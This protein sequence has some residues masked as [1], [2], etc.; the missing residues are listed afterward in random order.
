MQD[1]YVAD[2]GDFSKYALLRALAG[3][4]DPL[5]LGVLW[6]LYPDEGHNSD[7]RHIGYL[8]QPVMALHDPITHAKLGRLVAEGRRSVAAVQRAEILPVGTRF[9]SDI[10]AATGTPTDR[11]EHR[12]RWFARGAQGMAASDLVF[13]DPDNGIE[14]RALDKRSFRAGKYVFWSEIEAIWRAGKSL[15]VYNHLNRSAPAAT[16]TNLLAVEF[17]RR[18]PDAAET[19]PLLFRRGS[20]RHMWIIVQEG[21]RHRLEP[22]IRAFLDQGWIQDADLSEPWRSA[23]QA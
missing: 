10:V 6:Y 16:Q 9:F 17:A 15:V 13:F 19:L 8:K 5:Q 4:Q 11:V 23:P 22:R 2:A 14:T 20:C 18:L 1:R 7:G 21:H 3:G 12:S